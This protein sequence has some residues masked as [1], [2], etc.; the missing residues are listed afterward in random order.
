SGSK[1]DAVEAADG[2]VVKI[3]AYANMAV[4]DV[5]ALNW[6]GQVINHTVIAANLGQQIS[7]TVPA[8]S[9]GTDGNFNVSYSI[10]DAQ[11]GASGNSPS[12]PV[13]LSRIVLNSPVVDEQASDGWINASEAADGTVVKIP[14]YTGMAVGDVIALN[15]NGQVINRTLIAVDIGQEVSIT[16]PAG[17]MGADGSFQ[18]NYVITDAQGAT[19]GPSPS[20]LVV[21]DA[22]PPPAPTIISVSDSAARNFSSSASGNCIV[23]GRAEALAQVEVRIGGVVVATVQADAKGVWQA[24]INLST[25]AIG[26]SVNLTITAK[27]PLT[28]NTSAAVTQAI[29]HGPSGVVVNLLIQGDGAGD[30]AGFS[31]SNAGDV[32]GDGIADLIVG[33]PRGDDGGSNAGE[34]YVI[35]GRTDGNWGSVD[36]TGRRVLNLANLT[37]SEGFV[38]QGDSAVDQ[39][40]HSVS[41]AGDVNG[42]GIADLI[43]GANQGGDGG[44][45]AGEAYVIFGRADGN[46]GGVDGT[47]RRVLDLTSL[48][49]SRGFIIQGDGAGDQAGFSV[50]GAG[51][52]NGDGIAD[53]IIGAVAGDDGGLNTGEAYVVFGRADGNW[54]GVDG[55][56]RRVLDL[57]NLAPGQGFI[58]QGDDLSTSTGM[59]V[60][61]AGDVNGDGIDDLIIGAPWKDNGQADVGYAYVVFGR[62]D[63]N[64]GSVDGTGRRTLNVGTLPPSQ[65]FIIQGD[66]IGNDELGRVVSNAGDVNGDGIDDLI[67]GASNA[68]EAYVVFGRSDGNWGGVDGAGRQVL[69]VGNLT[70]NQGFI[71]RG[72]DVNRSVSSAGDVNGDGIADIVVHASAQS[73]LIFGRADGNW[74]GVDGTGRRVLDLSNLAQNQGAVIQGDIGSVSGA[75]D[76]NGDGIDDLIVGLPFNGAGEAHVI[77]GRS[78]LNGLVHI[79]S[80]GA[81]W[82]AGSQFGD[83]LIGGGGADV[84][85]GHGGN[86]FL[87]ASGTNFER[88]DGGAGTDT[89]VL[90]GAGLHLNLAA[91]GA[92]V[93]TGLEAIDLT[94]TGANTLSVTEQSLQALSDATDT[95]IVSTDAGDV[96]NATG[97]SKTGTQM[98]GNTTYD[99]YISGGATLWV[100]QAATVVI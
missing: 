93:L 13:V 10:T 12:T 73:Y 30:W 67:V 20:T 43:V 4:G 23:S 77:F 69:G 60:S 58:I 32:N 15:W 66:G 64:W 47:G 8:S 91:L 17:S 37:P 59:S 72:S 11:G 45:Q 44:A 46:W 42:D 97:F 2:T 71:I 49:P 53:L 51:D 34:A 6:N 48:A 25:V 1:I 56:G 74:G 100:D 80:A 65:G 83:Q 94:G 38:I 50:S 98:Q 21:L 7:I 61:N 99:I 9:L 54:G 55:T 41:S 82:L 26:G 86:D 78:D 5:I 68:G 87:T 18:V 84:L 70:P 16:V 31:V 29:T 28:G 35:F 24:P 75:G 85:L 62:A 90:A 81:D 36:G 27:D 95:L 88:I 79:G 52:V 33:A 39:M 19:S 57:T 3:P 22:T 76:V 92:Q 96:V 40:G 14:A 89:L 63:G